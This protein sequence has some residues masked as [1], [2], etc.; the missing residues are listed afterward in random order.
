MELTGEIKENDNMLRKILILKRWHVI[1]KL[2]DC[3][4]LNSAASQYLKTEE[5][6]WL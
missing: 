6:M 4:V 1:R 2:T 5:R 3:G